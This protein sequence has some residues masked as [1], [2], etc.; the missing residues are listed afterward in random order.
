VCLGQKKRGFAKGKWNGAGGKFSE[1]ETPERATIREVEEEFS[2]RIREENLRK[3]GVIEF[4]FREHPELDQRVHI[5]VTRAWDGEPTESE[6]MIPKWFPIT[7][8][9][10]P[11]SEMWL[12]DSYW[13]IHALSTKD[14]VKGFFRFSG[15]DD[16]EKIEDWS[17]Q[18]S[19]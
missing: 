2:V 6:E 15:K 8:H 16:S 10:I 3:V 14:T 13:L 1:G 12:D 4:Y 17:L 11:F 18:W 19:S 7:E 9:D 5:F